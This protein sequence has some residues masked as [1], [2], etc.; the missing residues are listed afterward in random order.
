MNDK[1]FVISGPNLF[2]M[3]T[4]LTIYHGLMVV[5]ASLLKAKKKQLDIFIYADIQLK[6]M[7]RKLILLLPWWGDHRVFI[8]LIEFKNNILC[9]LTFSLIDELSN[10]FKTVESATWIAMNHVRCEKL[11][12]FIQKICNGS[13]I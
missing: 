8:F 3:C 2:L 10:I 7:N 12:S 13:L 1:L 6:N 11:K 4:C 5:S 9:F